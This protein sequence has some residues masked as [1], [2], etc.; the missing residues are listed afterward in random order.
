MPRRGLRNKIKKV[1]AAK[2]ADES[3]VT[4]IITEALALPGHKKSKI[5]KP[6]TT[7]KEHETYIKNILNENQSKFYDGSYANIPDVPGLIRYISEYYNGN[8][9][10][11][12]AVNA[13]FGSCLCVSTYDYYA[14]YT[15]RRSYERNIKEVTDLALNNY[16]FCP[17]FIMRVIKYAAAYKSAITKEMIAFVKAMLQNYDNTID[18]QYLINK[19]YQLNDSTTLMHCRT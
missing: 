3:I 4:G 10:L 1:P 7:F 17:I 2:V 9:K 11:D 8:G 18:Y 12:D 19:N 5:N 16:Q 13:L 6:L 14:G 15:Y